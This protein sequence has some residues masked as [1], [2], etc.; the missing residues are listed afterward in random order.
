M[1]GN[2]VN[3]LEDDDDDDDGN[4]AASAAATS[5]IRTGAEGLAT[6]TNKPAKKEK[7]AP[8]AKP[9]IATIHNMTRSS[10]EDEEE[11]GQVIIFVVSM[12]FIGMIIGPNSS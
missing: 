4:V 8:T 6:A 12:E 10:S 2:I 11:Q 7:K 9:R 5:F 3:M 1:D